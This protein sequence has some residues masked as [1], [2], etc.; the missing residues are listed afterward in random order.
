MAVAVATGVARDQLVE[1]ARVAGR[2]RQRRVE[3]GAQREVAVDE[4]VVEIE[5]QSPGHDALPRWRAAPNSE[6]R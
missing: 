6:R 4:R 2:C 1:R 3:P 5:E